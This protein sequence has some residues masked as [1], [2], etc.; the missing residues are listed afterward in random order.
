MAQIHERDVAALLGG[1]VQRGSGNQW[2]NPGDG[3]NGH[4]EEFAFAWD[5]KS[6]MSLS[7]AVGRETWRKI[8]EQSQ[9]LRPA[10]PV[11]FY[12]DHSHEAYVDLIVIDLNDFVEMRARIAELE[13]DVRELTTSEE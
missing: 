11:R 9:G 8:K 12:D 7:Y 1:R 13:A 2:H 10:I 5:C 3:V 4:G 6:T